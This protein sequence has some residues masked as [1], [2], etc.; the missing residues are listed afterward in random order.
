[1]LTFGKGFP[2]MLVLQVTCRVLNVDDN[3]CFEEEEVKTSPSVSAAPLGSDPS[4]PVHP[5]V[6]EERNRSKSG[7]NTWTRHCFHSSNSYENL[8]MVV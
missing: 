6:G 4:G 1:L 3:H 5:S 2:G 7:D 8:V